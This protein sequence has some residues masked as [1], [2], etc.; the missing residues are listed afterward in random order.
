MVVLVNGKRSGVF[1]LSR[2]A[3]QICP[4][5]LLFT[6]WSPALCRIGLPGGARARVSAYVDNVS[7]FVSCRND[8]EV[9]QKALERYKKVM[10]ANINRDMSTGL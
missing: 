4:L 10:E 2:S 7:I 1:E 5:S 8:F 9:L 6:I 3:H